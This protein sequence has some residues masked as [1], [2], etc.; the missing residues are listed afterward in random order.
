MF[1][2]FVAAID[3]KG[4]VR[5]FNFLKS[6][7]AREF[8]DQFK[9]FSVFNFD[10]SRPLDGTIV[11]VPLRTQRSDISNNCPGIKQMSE[12]LD[13]YDVHLCISKLCFVARFSCFS[14]SIC[15]VLLLASNLDGSNFSAEHVHVFR[16]P[17]KVSTPPLHCA[18]P[19]S[20]LPSYFSV[21]LLLT[22][23][24]LTLVDFPTPQ[25]NAS[26]LPTPSTIY[27][28]L[29]VIPPRHP[30]R[31]KILLQSHH[32]TSLLRL[33]KATPPKTNPLLILR[34]HPQKNHLP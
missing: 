24:F 29:S 20:F 4:V 6:N 7:M 30:N 28:F 23:Y 21:F 13:R 22:F 25:K 5:V 3:D 8:V 15:R 31:F 12:L 2:Y 26:C 1:V 33:L 16:Y 14:A 10:G 32:S 17:H 18:S 9:P 19:R 27:V 34:N 11:R